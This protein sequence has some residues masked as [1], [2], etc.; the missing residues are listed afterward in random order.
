MSRGLNMF[1]D[2]GR[3]VLTNQ[4][5]LDMY[6]LSAD[7][8]KA[9]CPI[10]TLVEHRIE[11]GSFFATDPEAYIADLLA[12]IRRRTPSREVRA[13]PDGR[14]IAVVNQ[15]MEGGGWVVTHEDMT[16]RDRAEKDLERTR[17]FLE[18]VI[19]NV[20]AIIIVKNADDLKYLLINRAGEEYYGV[21]RDE[22]IGRTAHEVFR[23]AVADR[24]ASFDRQALETRNPVLI[25]EHALV[26]PAGEERTVTT[27][28][29]P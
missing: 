26:T 25:N 19:E 22:M 20:P 28:R 1:N 11:R 9:G 7:V 3:L 4:R 15:P 12:M 13:I 5:Y 8:V 21:S 24:I 29:L 27:T 10:R 17:L 6:G 23:K 16:D 14:T 18:T 2:S